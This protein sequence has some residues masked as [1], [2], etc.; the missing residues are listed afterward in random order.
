MKKTKKKASRKTSTSKSSQVV[1]LTMDLDLKERLEQIASDAY[2]SVQIVAQVLLATGMR[3]GGNA[4]DAALRDA[5]AT[6]MELEAKLCRCQQVMEAND[7][8][9]ARDIFGA[10]T[11]P[12]AE[13][14][15]VAASGETAPVT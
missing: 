11:A 13:T 9:N 4:K 8:D 7:P 15:A 14:P 3:M 2:T 12:P 10:P 6:V 5:V 1:T